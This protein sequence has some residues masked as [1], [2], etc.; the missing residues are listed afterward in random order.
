MPKAKAADV[1]APP[2]RAT[3]TLNQP[4]L[5]EGPTGSEIES[6]FVESLF[7]GLFEQKAEPDDLIMNPVRTRT[8]CPITKTC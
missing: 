8:R 3:S 4:P 7:A 1:D 6:V 2:R 5:T